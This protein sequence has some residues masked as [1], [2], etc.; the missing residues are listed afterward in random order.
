V[1]NNYGM[2][3]GLV[4][5]RYRGAFEH[6]EYGDGLSATAYA[7]FIEDNEHKV[8]D[9]YPVSSLYCGTVNYEAFRR[10]CSMLPDE[11]DFV[12]LMP[13]MQILRDLAASPRTSPTT[14]LFPTRSSTSDRRSWTTPKRLVPPGT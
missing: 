13:D 8:L 9:D 6:L 12:L 2:M 10:F 5:P 7:F 14:S 1:G 11:F 3:A 4:H